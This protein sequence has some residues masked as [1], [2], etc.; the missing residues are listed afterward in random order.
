MLIVYALTFF[1][2]LIE[3]SY[4]LSLKRASYNL[5]LSPVQLKLLYMLF[6][7]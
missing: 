5:N 6:V 1:V 2:T 3:N 7:K 4:G